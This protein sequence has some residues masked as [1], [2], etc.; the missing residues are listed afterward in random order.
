L[1]EHWAFDPAVLPHYAVH[2][3]TG[4]PMPQTLADRLV[5]ARE[6]NAGYRMTELLAAAALDMQWHTLPAGAAPEDVSRFEAAALAG[7][8]LDLPEVP[9]RYRSSYFLHIWGNNYGAGY[10]ASLWAEMLADDAFEWFRANGG[11]TRENG[12]RFRATVLS[13]GNTEDYG[14]M[15]R[16]LTGHDPEIGPMLEHR[17]L[18]GR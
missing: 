4:Q 15:Y 3:Q 9:P 16:N 2:Q 18:T 13:R 1:N 6:L 10:Y 5:G 17:G 8:R 7:A 14:T 11:L 12:D